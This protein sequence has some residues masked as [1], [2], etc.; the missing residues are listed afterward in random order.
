[1]TSLSRRQFLGIAGGAAV[2]GA[3]AG[4]WVWRSRLDE[5]LTDALSRAPGDVASTGTQ[6]SG[7]HVPPADRV[8]VVVQ[9]SGGNDGLNTLVPAGDGRYFDARPTLQVKEND[10][11]ALNGTRDYGLHPALKPLVS[12]WDKGQMAAMEAIGIPGQTRSHFAAMDTWWS[13]IP[14]QTLRNGWIGR[15]LDRGG[16]PENPLRAIALGGTSP[17]L[18]GDR[19]LSTVVLDPGAFA[20]RAPKGADA[21]VLRDAFLA[22]AAPVSLDAAEASAQHAVAASL[23]AVDL[24]SRATDA[25][26]D[27]NARPNPNNDGPPTVTEL[28]QTAA[29]IID[30]KL[31]TQVIVVAGNNFDTHSDQA[32]RHPQLLTDVAGGI[33]GFLDTLA[34]K[35]QA[36]S[37]LVVTTSEFGRRVEENGSGTDHGSGGVQFLFGPMVA[38]QIIGQADLGALD[39]G[40]VRTTIDTRSLYANALDWLSGP[41]G[42]TD[43]ILGGTTY[44]R[45]ALVR[46]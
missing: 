18:L 40:D 23:D 25:G 15:W 22:T 31:G 21:K 8:L 43:E 2:G 12:Y 1:M 27:A 33:A 17:A 16:D 7:W 10:V 11:V 45:Y 44:D 38:G 5:H 32:T 26:S 4:T 20:L 30:L 19:S 24:L 14:G 29:G 28:L 42:P 6:A 37:V 3:V 36:D 46:S 34:K 9:L 41:G 35:G 13:A 39:Q